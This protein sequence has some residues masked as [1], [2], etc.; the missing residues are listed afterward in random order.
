MKKMYRGGSMTSL[1]LLLVLLS[2][3]NSSG[4]ASGDKTDLATRRGT[5]HDSGGLTN[6][7][8]VTSS[9]GMLNWIHSNTTNLAEK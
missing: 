8:M 1:V 9:V 7:L 4:P 2:T 3:T 5:T 6:V